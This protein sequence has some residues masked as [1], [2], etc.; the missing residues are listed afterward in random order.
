MLTD[1]NIY[2][3]ETAKKNHNLTGQTKYIK[4]L[5]APILVIRLT[6]RKHLRTKVTQD[7]NLTYKKSG[8]VSNLLTEIFFQYFSRKSYVVSVY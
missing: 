8:L 2:N 3:T 1:M 4:D 6:S 5:R 7:F